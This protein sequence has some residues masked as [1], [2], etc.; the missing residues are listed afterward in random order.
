[1]RRFASRKVTLMMAIM[2]NPFW[3]SLLPIV[4]AA[5]FCYSGYKIWACKSGRVLNAITAVSIILIAIGLLSPSVARVER[6]YYEGKDQFEWADVLEAGDPVTRRP[7]IEAVCQL[8]QKHPNRYS[9]QA[10]GAQALVQAKATE[11]IPL[12]RSMLAQQNEAMIRSPLCEALKKLEGAERRENG[13]AP[14]PERDQ[15]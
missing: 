3:P 4:V 8:M 2:R 1:M 13:A 6:V 9:V 7:A 15:R 5:A 10:I 11:T 12:L 14:W